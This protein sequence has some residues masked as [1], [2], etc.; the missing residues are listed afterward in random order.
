M[1]PPHKS[2]LAWEARLVQVMATLEVMC[3]SFWNAPT[4]HGM[5]HIDHHMQAYGCFKAINGLVHERY[6]G[7]LKRLCQ[8][9][10]KNKMQ[11]LATQINLFEIAN[12]WLLGNQYN[13]AYVVV[14]CLLYII[15]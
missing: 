9:G 3:P 11:T 12:D 14:M 15:H 8:H 6:M 13:S 7:K 10:D 2:Y 5:L 1:R 4:A